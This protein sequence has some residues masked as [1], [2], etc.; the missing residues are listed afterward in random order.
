[1]DFN[2]MLDGLNKEIQA[3]KIYD[4]ENP[5]HYIKGIKYNRDKDRLEFECVEE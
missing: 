2:K 1:M 3:L 5:G 4:N